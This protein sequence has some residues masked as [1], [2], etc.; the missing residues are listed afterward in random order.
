MGAEAGWP[1]WRLKVAKWKSPG[2]VVADEVGRRGEMVVPGDLR[3][4]GLPLV[5]VMGCPMSRF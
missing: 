1:G 5:W 4:S 3:R 2:G